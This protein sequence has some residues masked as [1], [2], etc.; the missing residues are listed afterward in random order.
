MNTKIILFGE[1]K[2]FMIIALLIIFLP[3]SSESAE[4]WPTDFGLKGREMPFRPVD[5]TVTYQNPPDFSWPKVS[6]AT[7]YELIIARDIGLRD[8]AY[9]VK[10]LTTNYYN[11]PHIFEINTYYWAVRFIAASTPSDWSEP[12]MFRID[13]D[14]QPFI[15]P[16]I[17]EILAKVPP[18]HPRVWTT[19]KTLG[20]FRNR[21]RSIVDAHLKTVRSEMALTFP[22][23]PQIMLG[24]MSP[25]TYA[26]LQQ[27]NTEAARG[28][29]RLYRA[30]VAYLISGDAEIG[31][32]AKSALLK[33][34]SWDPNG[35]TSYKN[36]DQLHRDIARYSAMVYDWIYDLLTPEERSTVLN[37]IKVR[38]Q[39]MVDHLVNPANSSF[40]GTMPFESHGWTASGYI[41]VIGVATLGDIP[42]AEE[43]LRIIIPVYA[44][45]LP[46]W[47]G[48][49]GGWSQG[50][51]YWMSSMS[52]GNDIRVLFKSMGI[53][54]LYDKAHQR[55]SGKALM[56]FYP[57]NSY[58]V[59][60]DESGQF[61]SNDRNAVANNL[62]IYAGVYQNPQ[63]VWGKEVFDIDISD[64]MSMIALGN[65][66]PKAEPPNSWERSYFAPS[67]GWVVMHSN[68][69]D[70]N[71][72]SLWFKSSWYGSFNHS[73]PDQNSF[74]IQA[75]GEQLAIDAG[76]YDYY[77]SDHDIGFAKKT[78]AHNAITFNN[79][80]G[81]PWYDITA[82]GSV[83]QYV[84][85][86]DFDAVTGDA[87]PAYKGDLGKAV[88]HIVFIRPDMFIVIDDLEAKSGESYQFEWF[89]NAETDIVVSE[90]K[91]DARITQKDAQ[92]DAKMHY[93]TNI[94]SY[95]SNIFAGPDGIE[96]PASA[97]RY[98]F[99][100]MQPHKRVWFQTAKVPSTIMIATLDVHKKADKQRDIR[101]KN[102]SNYTELWF[103][104]GTY[105]VVRTKGADD[106][107]VGH[108]TF[109]GAALVIKG[110]S[111]LL[112]A[113]T[114]LEFDGVSVIESSAVSTVAF[115][116]EEIAFSCYEEATIKISEANV[117]KI[118]DN[119]NRNI[120]KKDAKRMYGVNWST[121]DK[122]IVFEA[123]KGEYKYYINDRI[124]SNK[125][126]LISFPASI[127]TSNQG[128][129]TYYFSTS[130]NNNNDG[131][132][133]T[134][135]KQYITS[136]FIA[137]LKPGDQAL[138]KRGDKWHEQGTV[139]NFTDLKGSADKPIIFGA[140][141]TGEAPVVAGLRQVIGPWQDEGSGLWSTPWP[142]DNR[143]TLRVY[144]DDRIVT[145]ALFINRGGSIGEIVDGAYLVDNNRLYLKGYGNP[146]GKLVEVNVAGGTRPVHFENSEYIT[147][148]DITFKGNNGRNNIMLMLVPNSNLVFKN[149][150]IMHSHDYC[151]IL[152]NSNKGMSNNTDILFDN[153]LFDRTWSK[154]VY[155]SMLANGSNQITA[156]AI[157]VRNAGERIHITGC[158]FRNWGHTGINFHYY[159]HLGNVPDNVPEIR[160]NIVE[161]CV[162]DIGDSEYNRAFEFSGDARLHSNIF[163]YNY[164]YGHTGCSHYLGKNNIVYSNI[165]DVIVPNTAQ[166]TTDQ[167]YHLDF[168]PWDGNN[169]NRIAEGNVIINNTFYN[170]LSDIW[171]TQSNRI[172][173]NIIAN[174]IFHSY[175]N[176]GI[177][178]H[179]DRTD[180]MIMNNVFWNTGTN[181][182]IRRSNSYITVEQA[183]ELP[184]ID[185]N[186]FGNPMCIKIESGFKAS[187][188]T[189]QPGS[190]YLKAGIPL[191]SIS[192]SDFPIIRILND[193][194]AYLDFYG[195][196]FDRQ[197]PTIG[198]VSTKN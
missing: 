58:S 89:L 147:I 3:I 122:Y 169:V 52:S 56:Y 38:T 29:Q 55:N 151:V 5:K 174:N 135:P 162:F 43:W 191:S 143:S 83:T 66:L 157:C 195:N 15:V 124:L 187:D 156:D 71:R 189:L 64:D 67:I 181:N 90:N 141:G 34:T 54:N 17:N 40:I 166:T 176:S 126:D 23:E 24:T 61:K 73:H 94:T 10:N 172:G 190:P 28:Y 121:D 91:T 182:A 86:T 57:N 171:I 177:Y 76:F 140:Y 68:L 138:L 104:D 165:F 186:M 31:A 30:G 168:G 105:A 133:E 70:P 27:L 112:V 101:S 114:K 142:V 69:I 183:N 155:R 45:V 108:H 44:N 198:A 175:R 7:E 148:R 60:G 42:E 192:I 39:T 21:S 74:I 84:T 128:S 99:D 97:G 197:A 103:E 63:Y 178:F 179:N 106:I 134:N 96:I 13:P 49:D 163:R 100:K 158:T 111:T 161:K 131:L 2:R 113:G 107:T 11:F 32:Y 37:M 170:S 88:R 150:T 118:Y 188:F 78:Y 51:A 146:T 35:A 152:Q 180:Q 194:G 18:G 173:Q 12:R 149:L 127:S 65:T 87:T 154:T 4:A 19:K 95:Y 185:G 1:S 123:L 129:N 85:H 47:G 46:P 41:G 92:L 130:G 75:Y 53:L 62:E 79:G 50:T 20:D 110:E 167:Q 119:G 136:D 98:S 59:F 6:N 164:V 80:N 9:Q 132:S 8:I 77:G 36:Q 193:P 102:S 115:G 81:Q 137:S 109:N 93:P 26:K 120:P 160:N 72:V 16:P 14:A 144:V 25:D 82:K 33:I 125:N 145:Q 116:K 153:C 196:L 117:E 159:E 184:N 22:E 139:W 48:E